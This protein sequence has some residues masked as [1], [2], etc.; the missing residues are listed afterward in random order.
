MDK[1]FN[2]LGAWSMD[3]VPVNDVA[4][5]PSQFWSDEPDWVGGSTGR[6]RAAF[7]ALVIEGHK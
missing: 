6:A 4:G 7:M 1:D 3:A 2:H 5:T